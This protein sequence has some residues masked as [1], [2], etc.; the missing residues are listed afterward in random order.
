MTVDIGGSMQH[1]ALTAPGRAEWI[2]VDQPELTGAGDALVRPVAVATCDLDAGINAGQYPM[3]LPYLLG[4]EFVAEVVEV[5]DDV[6]GVRP[7]D[8]VAVPFQISCGTCARCR[9]GATDICASVPLGSAYGLG[10]IGGDWG[11]AMCDRVRVPYADA[12]LMALPPG[13]APHTVASL[14]NLADGA[15]T[16]LPHIERLDD[17][18]RVLVVGRQSVGLYATA[19]ARAFGA[20]VTYVDA[21]ASRLAVAEG[22]GAT[23]VDRGE[24]LDR[25]AGRK[26]DR[27][28]VTVST[29]ATEAG[30]QF[31]LGRT[32]AGGVCTDTGIHLGEVALPLLR[33]YTLGATFVTG[34]VAA[35]AVLP[36]VLDRV[37]AG[38][39]DPS[40]VTKSVAAWADAP[41]AW[42]EHRG[43]LV[44]TR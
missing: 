38:A 36:A 33:M 31:A 25:A 12:M 39:L 26:L 13:V 10:R 9:R 35:R 6:R 22:L 14:D 4:H 5:A 34:R 40:V 24:A 18:K 42:S 1:L 27:F 20:E 15:R 43:K 16:V 2:E 29:D 32:D 17:D 23:V 28:P 30:L 21:S 44:L 8:L 3:P 41:A 7:G 19:V 11:G 37:A